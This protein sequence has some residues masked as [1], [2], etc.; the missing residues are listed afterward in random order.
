MML[1][2][3]LVM[4]GIATDSVEREY[5]VAIIKS[6]V[7]EKVY[8]VLTDEND[9]F[10]YHFTKVDY[11]SYSIAKNDMVAKKVDLIIEATP[12]K[13]ASGL[14]DDGD[15]FE[16]CFY[17]MSSSTTSNNAYSNAK[18]VLSAYSD[19]LRDEAFA[20]VYDDA[21]FVLKPIEIHS[22]SISSNEEN[23]GSLIGMILPFI[24]IISILTGA[25]Y[26]AIDATAGE[27]ERGTL[28]TIMTLPVKKSQIMI[29]K[30]LSVSTIAVFSAIL[31]L[32]SMFG[33]VLIMMQIVDLQGLGF[34]NFDFSLFVPAFISLLLCLPI[35][36]MFASAVSL[37]IC[38]F[39][40]SF[41]EANN[42][43]SPILI[44][45]MFAAM[46]SI[47]PTI[48]LNYKTAVIPVTNI[49]L[50]I[51]SVFSLDYDFK[52]V[53]IVLF[54]NLAYCVLMVILMSVLFSSEEVLFGE[55]TKGIHL[56]EL[57]AN[58]KKGTMPGYGDIILLF[59]VLILVMIYSGSI[60]DSGADLRHAAFICFIYQK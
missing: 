48:E 52:L 31:N 19:K 21:E 35:F 54:T 8:S 25:I 32:L 20:E 46:A 23:A 7:S 59:S 29:S 39:A 14:Y 56:F 26:P 6:T 43:T 13:D 22:E 17:H 41:K 3:L 4:K 27:R 49:A 47:L 44:V 60:F 12:V 36:S 16:I 9:D 24:L 33:M 18:E 34:A 57:H 10:D 50:L 38:I 45:F 2:S 37:C 51:K 5:K 30:F 53:A 40:R 15:L 11:N 1:L 42:I 55:G 28:E 58:M